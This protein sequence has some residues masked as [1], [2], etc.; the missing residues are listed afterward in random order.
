STALSSDYAHYLKLLFPRAKLIFLHR[1]PIDAFVSYLIS[2]RL[3]VGERQN[4]LSARFVEHWSRLTAGFLLAADNL[5]GILV[6]YDH[7]VAAEPRRIE[8]YLGLPL[9]ATPSGSSEMPRECE[10]QSLH[11]EDQALLT[12]QLGELALRLGYRLETPRPRALDITPQAVPVSAYLTGSTREGAVRKCAV[13]VPALRYIEPECEDAL[14]E[15]ERRGYSVIRMR[16]CSSIDQARS[17][18]ATVALD[19][20]FDETVWIDADTQFNPD[21]VDRLRSHAVPIVAGLCARKGPRLGLAVGAMPGARELL[22]GEGGGLVEVLYAGTGF[23]LVRREVYTAIQQRLHL[24]ICDEDKAHRAIPFFMPMLEDW[25]GRMS[26]LNE[27]YAFSRRA[28]LCGYKIMADTSIR[29][30]HIGPY[31]YGYE[32]AGNEVERVPTYRH[33]FDAERRDE[34]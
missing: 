24:P 31:R 3:G 21:A 1:N 19:E 5:G 26:Y 4:E 33:V 25:G 17:V 30:W 10:L 11:A 22:L 8:N 28:R 6:G 15:L 7:V 14:A 32:D 16:G 13:L 34:R 23:L 12:E 29:L 18:L 20:G 2:A 9:S 27:D